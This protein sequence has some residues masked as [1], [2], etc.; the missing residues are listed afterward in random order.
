MPFTTQ[1]SVSKLSRLEGAI[2]SLLVCFCSPLVLFIILGFA[3][4]QKKKSLERSYP[5][6]FNMYH[7][8]S[9]NHGFARHRGRQFLKS[10]Y[11]FKTV[12]FKETNIL[13]FDL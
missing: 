6:M 13:L 7:C 8:S 1:T 4:R 11:V 12:S 2:S 5:N 3:R 9:H 10:N